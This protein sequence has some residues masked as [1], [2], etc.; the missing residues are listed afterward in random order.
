M[1]ESLMTFIKEIKEAAKNKDF[2]AVEKACENAEKN[3]EVVRARLR[4]QMKK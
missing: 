1:I 3:L 4:A 2:A